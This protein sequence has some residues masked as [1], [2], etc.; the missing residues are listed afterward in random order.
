[1]QPRTRRSFVLALSFALLA[2]LAAAPAPRARADTAVR[3]V[4]ANGAMTTSPCANQFGYLNIQAAIDASVDGDEIRVAAGTYPSAEASPAV[5]NIQNRVLIIVGGYAD[6]DWTTTLRSRPTI[7]DAQSARRGAY[8]YNSAVLLGNLEIRNGVAVASP[9]GFKYGGGLLAERNQGGIVIL[10]G[11]TL[12]NNRADEAGGGAAVFGPLE[13]YD[14]VVTGNQAGEDGGGLWGGGIEVYGGEFTD[15]QAERHA[16][17]VLGAATISGAR[18]ANNRAR[19]GSGGA[20]TFVS[21][22]Q[23]VAGSTFEDNQAG[24]EG[25]ALHRSFMGGDGTLRIEGSAFRRNTARAGGAL[26]LDGTP[27][28]VDLKIG[29]TQFEGNSAGFAGGAILASANV[30]RLLIDGGRFRNNTAR[31]YAGGAIYVGSTT[32]LRSVEFT[33]NSAGTF[34]GALAQDLP[35]NMAP[36]FNPVRVAGSSFVGNSAGEAGGAIFTR[37]GLTLAHTRVTGNRA[38]GDGGGVCVSGETMRAPQATS[39]THVVLS[40]N[41]AGGDGGALSLAGIITI[42]ATQVLSNTAGGIG[43]ALRVV[44]PDISQLT[45]TGATL[46]NNRGGARADGVAA[47]VA[48]LSL[49]NVT[50]GGAALAPHAALDLSASFNGRAA[51]LRNTVVASH[52]VGISRT[53]NLALAGD[54]NAF[55]QNGADQLVEGA[56]VALPWA[57]PVTGDPLF[58]NP[59]AHDLRLGPGSPLLDAGDPGLAYA[60]QLDAEGQLVTAGGPPDVGGDET[61]SYAGRVYLPLIRAIWRPWPL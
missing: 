20:I 33:G 17:A 39:L 42:R 5:L 44:N 1:M 37:D 9:M 13:V 36:G 21:A 19:T 30:G 22:N 4:S 23:L 27:D 52:T 49:R 35:S 58:V 38:G 34:G 12:R 43:G 8:I 59:A 14:A 61:V 24:A 31:A 57:H 29:D 3:C 51:T 16:G 46:A 10:D 60:G 56:P 50:I 45:M 53:A 48:S 54:Y 2:A 18:F 6:D 47:D 28:G 55:F 25:G 41:S 7:V 26:A 15:N 32:I 40:A 11:V